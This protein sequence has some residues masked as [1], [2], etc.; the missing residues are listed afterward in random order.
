MVPVNLQ[1]RLSIALFAYN[2]LPTASFVYI[3]DCQQSLQAI[4]AHI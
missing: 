2:I 4:I 1:S 3:S